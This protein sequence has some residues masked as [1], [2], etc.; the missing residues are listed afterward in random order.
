MSRTAGRLRS[1]GEALD[2]GGNV[3]NVVTLGAALVWDDR[4]D[5]PFPIRDGNHAPKQQKASAGRRPT[6]LT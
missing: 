1:P 4:R 3:T 6:F 5:W 2:R